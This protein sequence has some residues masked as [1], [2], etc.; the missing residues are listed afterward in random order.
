MSRTR[1]VHVGRVRE[2]E[3]RAAG[4]GGRDH[5]VS[6]QRLQFGGPRRSSWT[7]SG[8]R[9]VNQH[10]RSAFRLVVGPRLAAW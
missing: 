6:R 4:T 3:G 2:A 1:L 10:Q 5:L 7:A 9:A 8:E